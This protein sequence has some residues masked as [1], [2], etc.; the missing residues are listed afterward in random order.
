[1]NTLVPHDTREII[2]AAAPWRMRRYR[3]TGCRK[4]AHMIEQYLAW[5]HPSGRSPPGPMPAD[6]RCS[7]GARSSRQRA[8]APSPPP[9]TD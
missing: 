4:P 2:I 7:N 3:Q 1:M 8:C 9:C 6:D 5:M